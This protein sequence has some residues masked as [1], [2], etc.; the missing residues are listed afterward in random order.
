MLDKEEDIRLAEL[1]VAHRFT[2]WVIAHKLRF[3]YREALAALGE[4]RVIR[5]CP[6][7]DPACAS[8]HLGL[9]DASRLPLPKGSIYWNTT[10][11]LIALSVDSERIEVEALRT[12]E[13]DS[14]FPHY[15]ETLQATRKEHSSTRAIVAREARR[16]LRDWLSNLENRELVHVTV[17]A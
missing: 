17:D 7:G 16:R 1:P 10:A 11:G 6:C 13:G 2:A 12:R 15:E 14:P 8:M 5:I 3:S 4:S 9:P